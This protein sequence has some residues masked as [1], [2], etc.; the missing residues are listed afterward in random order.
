MKELFHVYHERRE[1]TNISSQSWVDLTV[2]LHE[3]ERRTI[4]SVIDAPKGCLKAENLADRFKKY[5]ASYFTFIDNPEIEPSNNVSER[6]VRDSVVIDRKIK[7][8]TQSLDGNM[9]CE[10]LWSIKHT[11]EKNGINITT[12]LLQALEAHKNGT[13]LPSLVN[14]GGFV[15][16]KYIEQAKTEFKELPAAK[17]AE[18][19]LREEKKAK[20]KGSKGK[21]FKTGTNNATKGNNSQTSK[22]DG[23]QD[24][25]SPTD[26]KKTST[27]NKKPPHKKKDRPSSNL[28]EPEDPATPNLQSPPMPE[29]PVSPTSTDDKPSQPKISP[30]ELASQ[31]ELL[32]SLYK[33][34]VTGKGVKPVPKDR[35][36]KEEAKA[37]S[38]AFGTSLKPLE[39][40]PTMR[41]LK[42]PGLT[43]VDLEP[44]QMDLSTSL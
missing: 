4:A 18:A 38:T 40:K 27:T 11:A 6:T 32:R 39:V 37:P 30:K 22:T 35:K 13:D 33:Q 2:K 26:K 42:A 31:E 24:T 10:T 5:G 43:K 21:Y 8:G 25:P 44:A 1:I 20:G 15:E 34:C 14:I 12:F 17:T 36:V 41:R 9:F 28:T 7:L 29:A 19:K 3:I 23:Q 16:Q